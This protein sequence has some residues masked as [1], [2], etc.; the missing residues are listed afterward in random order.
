L[1]P[2]SRNTWESRLFGNSYTAAPPFEKVK[3]GCLNIFNAGG[4]VPGTWG[5]PAVVVVATSPFCSS[6][7][8]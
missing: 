1:S 2:A 7:A 4:G 5:W 3:Y 6:R 8:L